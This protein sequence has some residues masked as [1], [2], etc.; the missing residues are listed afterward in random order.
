MRTHHRA[1]FVAATAMLFAAILISSMHAAEATQS[2]PAT[3]KEPPSSTYQDVYNGWKWWHV[4]CYRC[5]GIDAVGTTM[6]PSLIDPANR[7]SA[8]EFLKLVR[9]GIVDRGMPA[10]EKLLDDKQIRQV[11]LYVRARA[12][13]LLPQGRPDEVGPNGGR[14]EPPPNWPGR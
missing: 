14:W 6:A 13:K 5:H 1:G 12:D 11:H 4:Y 7:R 8:R 3:A 2:A 9:G 10:W